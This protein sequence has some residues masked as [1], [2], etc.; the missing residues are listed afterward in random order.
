[1]LDTKNRV[2]QNLMR[3]T[4]GGENL[5]VQELQD[6]INELNSRF[7]RVTSSSL[8]W[9]TRMSESIRCWQSYKECEA[10][11]TE[12]ITSA[13][14]LFQEKA[15]TTK[16]YLETHKDFFINAPEH[17]LLKV[18]TSGQDL[19][20]YV[21]ESEKEAINVAIRSIQSRWDEVMC[22]A[23]LHLLKLEFRLDENTFHMY[24][25]DIE[26]EL[27]GE[28]NAYNK[29]ENVEGIRRR[30]EEF[31]AEN[32]ITRIEELLDNMDVSS[33]E[34]LKKK[35]DRGLLEDCQ[36][37]TV[38]WL[39]L[40]TR[41][42]TM[43]SQLDQIPERW[44]E[45][46]N[47][48]EETV[49]WMD[50]VNDCLK[51]V[52]RETSYADEYEKNK[53]K[54]VD[55]CGD[56]EARRESMKWLVQMLDSLITHIPEEDGQY[57]QQKLESLVGRYK[58]LVPT[59]ES[60]L[61]RTETNSKCYR[62]RE[63]IT[64]IV[65]SLDSITKKKEKSTQPENLE[66]V[67]QCIKEQEVVVHQ[68]ESQRDNIFST[69][70]R[71]KDLMR[72]Q[73]VPLF[74]SAML[75][76]LETK[77]NEAYNGSVETLNKLKSTQKVWS[78]YSDQKNE[79]LKL[80]S[81]AESELSSIISHNNP[82][83]V[84]NELSNKQEMNDH[85][86]ETTDQMLRKLH[87]HSNNLAKLANPERK[88]LLE[89]EVVEIEQKMQ[90]VIDTV[91]QK[92]EFLEQ[93]NVKWVHFTGTLQ[94]LKS[95]L[96]N[97]QNT[98]ERLVTL[99][100]S[101]EDRDA[102]TNELQVRIEE[103]MAVIRTLEEEAEE[104]LEGEP[105][106]DAL[107]F[108]AELSDLKMNTNILSKH[109][110]KHAETVHS[111][112]KHWEEYQ[113]EVKEIKPWLEVAEA[114]V[115]VGLSKPN[116]M[117]DVIQSS[118][119]AKEFEKECDDCLEKLRSVSSKSAQV[120][121]IC[122]V[123]D[124]IDALHSRWAAIHDVALQWSERSESLLVE[125]EDFNYKCDAVS[126]WIHQVEE[127]LEKVNEYA[128]TV[129]R[130]EDRL[131]ILKDVVKEVGEKQTDI[132]NLTSVGDHISASM[133]TEGS[134]SVK[135]TVMEL[136]NM[137]TK[138][139][140][141]MHKLKNELSD[142]T[143][144]RQ[145]FIA[146]VESLES[147]LNNFSNQLDELEDIDVDE[148]EGC[149]DMVH[150][151]QQEHD[152]KQNEVTSLAEECRDVGDRCTG[153]DRDELFTQFDDAEARFESYGE[154]VTSKK[155]A[156]LK[157]KDFLEWQ[158][159][160]EDAVKAISQQLETKPSLDDL[161]Q[162]KKELGNLQEQCQSW[163][164]ESS[165]IVDLCSK[166]SVTVRDPDTGSVIDIQCK[167]MDFKRKMDQL[168]NNLENR[169]EQLQEINSLWEAFNN[170][171]NQLSEFLDDIKDRVTDE[172]LI[173][174][175]YEG[176]HS[177]LETVEEALEEIQSEVKTKESLH[178]LGRNLMSS[179]SAQLVSVQNA[180]TTADSQW[181][182]VQ[183]M[184]YE[185]QTKFTGITSLWRQFTEGKECLQGAVTEA[186]Q[187]IETLESKLVNASSVQTMINLCKK[188]TDTL[189]KTRPQLENFITKSQH[190]CQQLDNE[191]GFDSSSVK[192]QSQ[193]IQNKWQCTM[194]L[195]N[196]KSQNLEG[197]LNLWKQIIQGRDE[198]L[199]WLT[200]TCEGLDLEEY[201]EAYKMDEVAEKLEKYRSELPKY[202]GLFRT[203]QGRAKQLES[204]NSG[205][206]IDKIEEIISSIS[207][208]FEQTESVASKLSSFLDE[209]KEQESS[210]NDDIREI[211]EVLAHYRERL[212][213][214]EDITGDDKKIVARL[215]VA[216]KIE[217]ELEE[218]DEKIK[219]V[220]SDI[221]DFKENFKGCEASKLVKEYSALQKKYEG[222][223][224]QA[225]K[226]CK[227]L[228]F[229]I[230][231]HYTDRLKALQRF[232]E[233]HKEKITWCQ[234]EPSNDRYGV[235]AKIAALSDIKGSLKLGAA[236]KKELIASQQLYECTVDDEDVEEIQNDCE[237]VFTDLEELDNSVDECQAS[238]NQALALWQQ[239]ELMTEN[240]SSWLKEVEARM[241]TE[242][243][244]QIDIS[245]VQ[246][247]IEETEALLE[248]VNSHDDEIYELMEK[249]EELMEISPDCRAGECASQIQTRVQ[250]LL[251]F[252]NTFL[253]KLNQ[254]TK[255]Q[256]LYGDTIVKME[257]WLKDAEEKLKGFEQLTRGGGKPTLAYQ[258][259]LQS[260]K[261]FVEEKK[262]G[263][264]LLNAVVEHG[265]ALFSAITPEGREKIRSD[266]R[267][268]RDTWEAHLDKVNQLYKRVE[269]IIMQW[270]S[271]DDNFS[272]AAK[273]LEEIQKRAGAK[274]ELKPTLSDKKAQLQQYKAISQDINSHE[275]MIHGL[276]E[277]IEFL[278]DDETS[279]TVDDM[280][281]QY[282]EIVSET[283][284]RIG[285][286]EEYIQQQETFLHNLEKFRDWLT[287]QKAELSMCS[288]VS[289]DS[290]DAQMKMSIFE[291]LEANKEEGQNLIDLCEESLK[292]TLKSTDPSGHA[293]IKADLETQKSSWET[294]QEETAD[295]KQNLLEV[296]SQYTQCEEMV[297][298]LKNW[299]KN[300]EIRVKDQSLKSN[301]EAK[302]NHLDHLRELEQE[303]ID[304][305][306]EINSALAQAQ[307]I[308]SE[309]KHAVQISQI[310]SRYQ[311]LK[312]AL[313][314]MIS[315]YEQFIREHRSFLEKYEE[316]TDWVDALD[317]D[318]REHAEVVGD[319]K[320][321][322]MRRNKVEQL[323]ELKSSQGSKVEA[324]LELGER[325][326]S[327][328]LLMAGR[329]LQSLRELRE[330]WEA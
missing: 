270:S 238:L 212:M 119:L 215:E 252:C 276:K 133:G 209:V 117:Q 189:R 305:G 330:R 166:A 79:I 232:T 230:E 251:Q 111:D 115:A 72:D 146:K 62:Y 203:L 295:G 195:L 161:I 122:P 157:W 63:D 2:Y 302:E 301:L 274:F 109:T 101:P 87:S 93:L 171:Q 289:P 107:Q 129:L 143:I 170:A 31:F 41:I 181:D 292:L 180:L 26:K 208:E 125:W 116:S 82:Q 13:E 4:N 298:S 78:D 104:L 222:V 216:R 324:V 202:E 317:Q 106:N 244:N 176:V 48:V 155:P 243:M 245:M 192:R 218:Y 167:V 60:T 1:M 96:T 278:T 322:Q 296:V 140:N 7:A 137:V 297:Q 150:R 293:A 21:A 71:G 37:C 299:L 56:L 139:S 84:A 300:V 198:L 145:E 254:L 134:S 103:K 15:I 185:M 258:S 80:I 74:V 308:D 246:E 130:L 257:E 228:Y 319:M 47:K 58:T 224:A 221:D 54:F 253:G 52:N 179:D 22:H 136:K 40:Q 64:K 237:A 231:K 211:N 132:I 291:S 285:L 42:G 18:V 14:K 261:S 24:V 51:E 128:P 273:W 268:L 236:K 210:I 271:F 190:L 313:K 188:T 102:Q 76:M 247:K 242:T 39:D 310:S 77:W 281:E 135:S 286:Y 259:K 124:E 16:N 156:I 88:P 178:E 81:Q 260:L 83:Q 55:I 294:L 220:E 68:L 86:S 45:Y 110:E 98:L 174:S 20:K 33:Q 29:N 255:D 9:E 112:L 265:E 233:V 114:K 43:A 303:I 229:V 131:S 205:T 187:N 95:W 315:R 219:A 328:L 267:T 269:S 206:S 207:S 73:N 149:P 214:C 94:E 235:E 154:S 91:S 8:N 239:Y 59:I 11:V 32:L 99:E 217:D 142:I 141:E 184:L 38:Q 66:S 234:G 148:L 284:R 306:P 46:E 160:T 23:P 97:A 320:I 197:Q 175:T 49:T 248:E 256:K 282:Q 92:I 36:R 138:L 100:M 272:Q 30:H 151:L 172:D 314:E 311:A 173:E 25:R 249:T 61:V 153:S 34:Y 65:A 226:A 263:Q 3:T 5:N 186:Q 165:D 108:S 147:W 262:N 227:N 196:Q 280:I 201:Q 121:R 240:L 127:R 159:N 329:V 118:E 191:E 200:D 67:L 264:Q 318:L 241:R 309:G 152:E 28:Q 266:L 279:Q 120:A 44:K 123:V 277:K 169:Q 53:E 90:T 113:E 27:N 275:S 19:Q 69:I 182:R 126:S 158:S 225:E 307:N 312:N 70:Q 304:K 250:A 144:V 323:I 290:S 177:L 17:L 6:K 326:Y 57:E 288:D 10:E 35:E 199:T 105:S 50:C 223:E 163:D 325:L 85:L 316:C 168:E 321:L 287:A 193:G 89:K 162:I 283:Q 204:L 194:D 164:D 183:N 75:Q 12:W 213:K 327:T